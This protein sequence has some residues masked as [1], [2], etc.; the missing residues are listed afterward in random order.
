MD[1][2]FY[3]RVIDN[4]WHG[5]DCPINKIEEVSL[6]FYPWSYL[7]DKMYSEC[8]ANNFTILHQEISSEVVSSAILALDSIDRAKLKVKQFTLDYS[9]TSFADLATLDAAIEFQ[10]EIDAIISEVAIFLSSVDNSYLSILNEDEV[11]QLHEDIDNL[12]FLRYRDGDYLGSLYA[13]V[14]DELGVIK[15]DTPVLACLNAF[16]VIHPASASKSYLLHALTI[17]FALDAL[18]AHEITT[19]PYW[20]YDAF[21]QL[22]GSDWL[23]KPYY[24][25]PIS[26]SET[27]IS[28]WDNRPDSP[29]HDFDICVQ[30]ALAI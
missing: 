3:G 9:L 4:I 1:L 13:C 28:L 17:T 10:S 8:C 11:P 22:G 20:A 24:N 21:K 15:D 18:F 30:A 19:I 12:R 16:K 27:A 5:R 29:M 14:Q 23:S 2:S 6:S 26:V 7:I 25:L